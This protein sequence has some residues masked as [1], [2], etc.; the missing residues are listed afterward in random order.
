MYL[1]KKVLGSDWPCPSCGGYGRQQSELRRLAGGF[2][3]AAISSTCEALRSQSSTS[4]RLINPILDS[5]ELRLETEG[6]LCLQCVTTAEA[7]QSH[8]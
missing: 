8:V 6:G 1:V 5:F 3:E 4:T 7:H 2:E